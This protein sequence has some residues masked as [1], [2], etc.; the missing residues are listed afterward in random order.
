M[1]GGD[2]L[3]VHEP[4]LPADGLTCCRLKQIDSPAQRERGVYNVFFSHARALCPLI[5][6]LH[7][8]RSLRSL[9][10]R[11]VVGLIRSSQANNQNHDAW[12]YTSA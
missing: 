6:G 4:V 3:S 8:K 7:V 12:A 10:E 11:N 5:V 1:T 2:W 9:Q